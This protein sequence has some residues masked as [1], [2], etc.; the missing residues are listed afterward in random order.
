MLLLADVDEYSFAKANGLFVQHLI[1]IN[2][3]EN[4]HVW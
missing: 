1:Q 2:S 3:K 4:V